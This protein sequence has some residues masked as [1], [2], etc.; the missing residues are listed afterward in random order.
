MES[1]T[2]VTGCLPAPGERI[3]DD[4]KNRST[5]IEYFT[6]RHNRHERLELRS[7]QFKG[8]SQSGRVI[9]NL[10][11]LASQMKAS[12]QRRIR[13]KGRSI[14]SRP[15]SSSWSGAWHASHSC[16]PICRFICY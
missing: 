8:A 9:S 4:A 7:F 3:N 10:S 2:V 6:K 12:L 15:L 1:R 16:D 13:A 11:S 14:V 5:L